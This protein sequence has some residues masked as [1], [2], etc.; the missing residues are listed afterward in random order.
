MSFG[1]YAAPATQL[2]PGPIYLKFSGQEQIAI[3]GAE[4]TCN[5]AKWQAG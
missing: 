1:A 5:D 4:N 2:P 3:N